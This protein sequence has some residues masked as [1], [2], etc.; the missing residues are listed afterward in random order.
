MTIL[1]AMRVPA[2]FGSFIGEA[3]TWAAWEAFLAALFSLDMTDG[4]L[5]LYRTHTGRTRAPEG[6]AREAWV[7]VG[8]RAGNE[9]VR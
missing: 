8:R 7:V 4:Q 1:E 9:R 6:P 3:E 2:L 5:A